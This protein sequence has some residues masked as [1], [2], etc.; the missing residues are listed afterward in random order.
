MT[1][2][3]LLDQIREANLGYLLL[4]QQMIAQDGDAAIYRLG[5]SAEAAEMLRNLTPG[6]IL[7]VANSNLLLCR[8][9]FDDRLM[10]NML[11]EYTTDRLMAQSHAAVLMSAQ[12][13]AGPV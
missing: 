10:R 9:R 7:K 3:K 4:A 11:T 2:D 13:T 6:Q 1:N 5:V 8:F 12:P